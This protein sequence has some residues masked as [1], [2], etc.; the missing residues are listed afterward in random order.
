MNIFDLD[1]NQLDFEEAR[2]ALSG[3]SFERLPGIPAFL[4]KKETAAILSVS[5]KVINKLT[6]SGELLLTDIPGDS[7]P[8]MD[9]FGDEIEPQRETCIL[10]ADLVNYIEKSLLCN[11]PVLLPETDR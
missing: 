10:R 7:Q 4:S 9:L 2:D 3:H 8:I 11:R 1:I 6:E 5:M